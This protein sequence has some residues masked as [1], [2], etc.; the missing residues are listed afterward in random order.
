M[1]DSDDWD[2]TPQ[3]GAPA[4]AAAAGG[5][6]GVRPAND[7]NARATLGMWQ[8]HPDDIITLDDFSE[9]PAIEPPAADPGAKY[10]RVYC[11]AFLVCLNK[12]YRGELKPSNN[13]GFPRL[14]GTCQSLYGDDA[15]Y[16]VDA[17]WLLA[18]KL[19]AEHGNDWLGKNQKGKG[20]NPV[21]ANANVIRNAEQF[22]KLMTKLMDTDMVFRKYALEK[23]AKKDFE[24]F[25]HPKTGNEIVYR[26]VV[27]ANRLGIQVLGTRGDAQRLQQL[28]TIV[29]SCIYGKVTLIE[30]T[31]PRAQEQ[32]DQVVWSRQVFANAKYLSM[33]DIP[34]FLALEQKEFLRKNPAGT[35]REKPPRGSA[36]PGAAQDGASRAER[37][38]AAKMRL[39][40]QAALT[41][42]AE[43]FSATNEK[44]E[45][46]RV[47]TKQFRADLLSKFGA[48]RKDA[49]SAA[50][51]NA[52]NSISSMIQKRQKL[53]S[54]KESMRSA[55][56]G[57]I[58]MNNVG[59]D[60]MCR[61]ALLREGFTTG[62]ALMGL[63]DKDLDSYVAEKLMTR[64][65]GAKIRSWLRQ[66]Q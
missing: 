38:D 29:R 21:L 66:F 23:A 62:A 41:A 8:I 44:L 47:G 4:A 34:G 60:T 39:E 7:Q 49:T 5:P 42:V 48:E 65:E 9:K 45:E 54:E 10:N 51:K 37:D 26:T 36:T 17:A 57:P 53:D 55:P 25:H 50:T 64:A 3:H 14:P 56:A 35:G 28:G 20:Q 24:C 40:Q 33:L 30:E 43:G 2:A 61:E 32:A 6:M 16:I 31:I 52:M 58:L 18:S 63:T 12:Y 15:K 1:A 19:V 46:D 11:Y 22:A 27:V 59:L 13:E